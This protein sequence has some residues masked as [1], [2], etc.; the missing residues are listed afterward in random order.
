MAK[1]QSQLPFTPVGKQGADGA[2]T[3]SKPEGGQMQ[4]PS[5][6]AGGMQGLQPRQQKAAGGPPAGGDSMSAM[7]ASMQQANH[8]QAQ[9]AVMNQQSQLEGAQRSVETEAI[10]SMTKSA[11]EAMKD[12]SDANAKAQ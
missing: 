10:R 9:M 12:L 6:A 11:K 2:P 4:K 7:M 8:M 3:T 1:V 5:R